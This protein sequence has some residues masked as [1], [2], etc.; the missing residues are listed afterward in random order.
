MSAAHPHNVV[1]TTV[2]ERLSELSGSDS[3]YST[4]PEH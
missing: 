4:Q 3:H 2:G 1:V